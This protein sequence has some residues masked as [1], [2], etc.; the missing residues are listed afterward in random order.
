M[1][2]LLQGFSKWPVNDCDGQGKEK[3]KIAPKVLT[4]GEEE[5]NTTVEGWRREGERPSRS[6]KVGPFTPVK[7]G[8]LLNS[9]SGPSLLYIVFFSF[10]LLK[11]STSD[12]VTNI[13]AMQ[14]NFAK[15]GEQNLKELIIS[16]VIN[17]E[18]NKI[19]YMLLREYKL[20]ICFMIRC[21]YT[22]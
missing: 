9:L 15:Q 18:K 5:D 22:V 17:V 1:Q 2:E 21:T 14:V 10:A 20:G 16:S 13:L 19:D 6:G 12:Q 3:P 7:T 11:V 8:L 4:Q